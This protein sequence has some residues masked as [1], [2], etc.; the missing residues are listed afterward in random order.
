MQESEDVK[1]AR[2]QPKQDMS[3][4]KVSKPQLATVSDDPNSIAMEDTREPQKQMPVR[5]EQKIGRNDP[6]PC[7]SGKKYKNCHGAGLE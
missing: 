1:E 6:C 3:K 2:P 4:L 5:A 7:G